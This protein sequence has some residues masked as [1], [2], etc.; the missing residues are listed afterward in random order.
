MKRVSHAGCSASSTNSSRYAAISRSC[1][2]KYHCACA[3]TRPRT[4]PPITAPGSDPSPPSIIASSPLTVAHMPSIGVICSCVETI[5]NPAVPPIADAIA[6]TPAITWP[7]PM[8]H[9]CAAVGLSVSARAAVPKRVRYRHHHK[10]TQT[11]SATASVISAS[12]RNESGPSASGGP[13][14]SGGN[15]YRW[16]GSRSVTASSNCIHNAKLPTIAAIAPLPCALLSLACG[17][18]HSRSTYAPASVVA[19]RAIRARTSRPIGAAIGDSS[20]TQVAQ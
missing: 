17:A 6:N 9:S 10:A 15:G 12:T 5:R 20:A 16:R 14:Y 19:A 11:S 8:P 4:S 3:S 13:E 1:G 2:P 7:G 18:K